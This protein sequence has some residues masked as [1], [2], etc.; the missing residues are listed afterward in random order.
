M[1]DEERY[2]G[3]IL[4]YV[5][6]I[7][8]GQPEKLAAVLRRLEKDYQQLQADRKIPSAMPTKRAETSR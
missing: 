7:L 1:S 5:D 2:Y 6:T 3:S 4:N 8:R